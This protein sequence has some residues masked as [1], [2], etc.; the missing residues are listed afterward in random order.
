MVDRDP[1]FRVLTSDELLELALLIDFNPVVR[2][3]P[4]YLSL[5]DL[6]AELQREWIGTHS[7]VIEDEICRLGSWSFAADK[8][9]R[10]VVYDLATKAEVPVA[11]SDPVE[12]VEEALVRRLVADAVAKMTPSQRA[13]FEA[14]VEELASKHGKTVF[15]EAAGFAALGAAQLSGF[16]IY[17]MSSTLLGTVNG[18]L[19]LGLGFGAFTGLSSL[20]ST[21]I[22]PVGWIGLGV[23]TL[24]KLGAPNYEK[25]TKAVL[26]L[27]RT[28]GGASLS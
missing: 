6:D 18:I 3:S 8:P 14:R 28:R 7:H 2:T 5:R 25:S 17:V 26:F 23:Y 22:G 9:Y 19:G 24:V 4:S 11:A 12:V 15:K 13:E 10:E 21:I 16:G 20:I 1:I 27:A